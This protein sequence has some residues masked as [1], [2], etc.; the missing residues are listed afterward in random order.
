[1]KKIF[2]IVMAIVMMIVSAGFAFATDEVLIDEPVAAEEKTSV[3]GEVTEE[4]GEGVKPF[5]EVSI[6]VQ[7]KYADEYSGALYFDKVMSSQSI[8]VG[9]DRN[10]I[11]IYIQAENFIPT[12][13]EFKE[14]DFC[15]GA[16][17]EIKG[18]K[19][20]VG[21]GRYWIREKG[22]IDY[23]GIY[24]EVTFPAPFFKI[25]PFI[26]GEYRFSERVENEDGEGISQNGFVYYGGLRREFQ[27]HE[28]VNLLAEVSVGGHTGIYGMPAENLSFAREKL[29]IS[30]SITNWL[31]VKASAMTQQNLGLRDG[32]AA[33][34]DKLFVSGVIVIS[35]PGSEEPKAEE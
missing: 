8:M 23:N 6:G 9:V 1:M 10:G 4:K 14:T 21:Y 16:Y 2:T 19:I 3:A 17:A 32:I 22:E 31:K 20:D 30:I 25:V 5:A 13:G 15:V 26:K 35:L 28:R 24:A 7:N 27:I 18:V 11:G 34:T 33:D 12:G 29:E